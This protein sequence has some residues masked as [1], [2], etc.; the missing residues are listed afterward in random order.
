MAQAKVDKN[1]AENVAAG[2]KAF[3]RGEH[4]T[5]TREEPNSL[6]PSELGKFLA[7]MFGQ[8]PQ[9]FAMTY[10]LPTR[11]QTALEA[12]YGHYEKTFKLWEDKGIKVPPCF[13]IVC[14][15]TAISKLVYDYVSGFVRKNDDGT[16]TLVN[17]RLALFRN[18]DESTLS[19]LPRPNTLLIDSEQLEAGDALDDNFRVMASDEIERFRRERVE[20]T[21]D[22][23][24]GET[25]V[26]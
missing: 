22:A 12:L 13:I 24:S 19:A 3:P 1:L 15:N 26:L 21:G 4:R 25:D 18:F 17:G 9:H 10:K 14:Q 16:S 11:L 2:I 6:T 20:R 7:C 8:F 23:R 5:Y